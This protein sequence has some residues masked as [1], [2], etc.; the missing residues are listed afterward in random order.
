MAELFVD[1]PDVHAWTEERRFY[2]S[3]Q[4]ISFARYLQIT[5]DKDYVELVDGVLVEKMAAHLD[6]EWILTWLL[7]VLRIMADKRKLGMVLGSRTAVEINEFRGRLPDILFVAEAR[8]DIV[9]QE[10]IYGA[11]DLVIEFPSPGDRPSD[12]IALETDYRHIGV[13]EIVFVDRRK[14]FIRILRKSAGYKEIVITSGPCTFETLP[15]IRLQAE[16]LLGDTR[17]EAFDLISELL[18]VQDGEMEG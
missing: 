18:A 15:D 14:K 13:L 7:S 16:W 11:P 9:H 4:P 5:G 10:A 6:H 8:R 12:L 17:P 1:E 3:D 2:G